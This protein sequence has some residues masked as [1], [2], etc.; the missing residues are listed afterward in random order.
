[1]GG[2][3]RV[4]SKLPSHQFLWLSDIVFQS[5]VI[6]SSV[7]HSVPS[8]YHYAPCQHMNWFASCAASS[9]HI[10]TLLYMAHKIP[11]QIQP[12]ISV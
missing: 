1:M 5:T 4:V 7:S 2:F 6:S 8:L 12:L 11:D 10:L 9:F 3:V